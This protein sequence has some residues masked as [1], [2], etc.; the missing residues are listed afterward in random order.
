MNLHWSYRYEE[1][2]RVNTP[3][4]ISTALSLVLSLPQSFLGLTE[5]CSKR[6][7]VI[8]LAIGSDISFIVFLKLLEPNLSF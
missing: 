7:E 5:I 3:V 4:L 2:S 1:A 6:I 8:L